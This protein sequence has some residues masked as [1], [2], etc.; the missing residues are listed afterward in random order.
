MSYSRAKKRPKMIEYWRWDEMVDPSYCSTT[1]RQYNWRNLIRR[2][3]KYL[4][5]EE[6]KVGYPD[7]VEWWQSVRPG[8][9]LSGTCIRGTKAVAT[10]DLL[11]SSKR[12][13]GCGW[14]VMNFG[15]AEQALN[16]SL[17]DDAITMWRAKKGVDKDTGEVYT[18]AE[19]D[20]IRTTLLANEMATAYLNLIWAEQGFTILSLAQG[21][22]Y[23]EEYVNENYQY[24]KPK[25]LVIPEPPYDIKEF[26]HA[27]HIEKT[28]ALPTGT[29]IKLFA[30]NNL[31]EEEHYLAKLSE[32]F[33]YLQS[34][35]AR[36]MMGQNYKGFL[37][38]VISELQNGPLMVLFKDIEYGNFKSRKP[39]ISYSYDA[40]DLPEECWNPRPGEEITY[41]EPFESFAEGEM[42]APSL[43][44]SWPISPGENAVNGIFDFR[45]GD[46]DYYFS[47]SRGILSRIDPSGK[48]VEGQVQVRPARYQCFC[49]FSIG[50]RYFWAVA[51][52]VD[53]DESPNDESTFIFFPLEELDSRISSGDTTVLETFCSAYNFPSR[54]FLGAFE[55]ESDLYALFITGGY[56]G[57]A[58]YR[59]ITVVKMTASPPE[60][61]ATI[62]INIS[63]IFDRYWD[64]SPD[65]TK[66]SAF[67][68]AAGVKPSTRPEFCISA[69]ISCCSSSFTVNLLFDFILVEDGVY[70]D[71]VTEATGALL[72]EV[73]ELEGGYISI[74][75][76]GTQYDEDNAVRYAIVTAFNYASPYAT[77][78]FQV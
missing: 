69:S 64:S 67:F 71:G 2:G 54:I 6:L 62:K 41:V 36:E 77:L 73:L 47:R 31:D 46:K 40:Q 63:E 66:G 49:G 72:R 25:Y 58:E 1:Y 29:K 20:T 57:S 18:G 30:K 35:V 4:T 5:F 48:V 39:F 61:V 50:D 15:P 3:E 34:I 22:H 53:E 70:S 44:V 23:E 55:Y 28:P 76:N 26:I 42:P 52:P 43:F 8:E 21:I 19:W 14:A 45:L 12:I 24:K 59:Y 32:A 56:E 68:Y 13:P 38:R 51:A 37:A 27:P 78:A 10:K 33:Q 16:C 17:L 7:W 65:E 74:V 11:V 60:R 9:D 75:Y